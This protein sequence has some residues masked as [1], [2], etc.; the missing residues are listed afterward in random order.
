M[1]A[2]QDLT[3]P[4][5]DRDFA[6]W[7][8]GCAWCAV[9]VVLLE[10][11]WTAAAVARGRSALADVLLPRYA[12]QPHITIAYRGLCEVGDAHAAREFGREAL[13][14]DIALLQR[15]AKPSFEL[16]LEGVG[17][18]S[19]VPYL[20]VAQG[21]SALHELHAALVP[22]EP[23][24]DWRYVPHVTLGHYAVQLPLQRALQ[25]LEE[26]VGVAKAGPVM[27]ICELTLVRYAACDI[28]GPLVLE[29]VF[30]LKTGRYQP[31]PGALWPEF[32]G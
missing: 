11:E 27:Q 18:F 19:S 12:R 10:G 17:S 5:E 22:E 29:G 6:E 21:V 4:C 13:Q 16:K 26:A 24:P 1:H 28:A 3:L 15:L 32:E 2:P 30:D 23:A 7:H 8:Q 14:A 31:A 9:W 25:Q 20:A